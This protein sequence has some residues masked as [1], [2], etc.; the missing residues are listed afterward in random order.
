[1]SRTA[2]AALGILLAIAGAR[3]EELDLRELERVRVDPASGALLLARVD[4]EVGTGPAA[5]RLE[6][7][8]RPFGGLR[9]E[10]GAH[11]STVLDVRLVRGEPAHVKS[12]RGAWLPVGPEAG[13][14]LSEGPDGA[15]VEGLEPG[16]AFVFDARGRL[17]RIETAA[18][19]LRLVR[20]EDGLVRALEGPWG[21]VAIERD[22]LGQVRELLTPAGRR[23]RWERD[24]QG[25][26]LSVSDGRA[27]ARYAYDRRGLLCELAGGLARIE[28]D[29]AGRVTRLEGPGVDPVRVGYERVAGLGTRARLER[30]GLQGEVLAGADGRSLSAREPGGRRCEVGFDA[31]LRP[32]TI[33]CEGE[34]QRLV[35]DERGL[36]SA[37]V[38]PRGEA[39]LRRGEDGRVVRVLGPGGL[40]DLGAAAVGDAAS[41]S[42]LERDAD[43]RLL[44][45]RHA[46]GAVTRLEDDGRLRVTRDAAGRRVQS[47]RLDASGRVVSRVDACGR[48]EA[49]EWSPQGRLLAVRRGEVEQARLE[50][51]AA[52]R[53]G[54]L[55]DAQ[56]GRTVVAALDSFTTAVIDP[57]CGREQV[58]LDAQGR[59]VGQV[60]GATAINL[61]RNEL[62]QLVGRRGPRLAETFR[63]DARGR[64]VEQRGG[65]AVVSQE[66]DEQGR[67]TRVR[68]GSGL[69][70]TVRFDARGR[71]AGLELPTGALSYERDAAGRLVAIGLGGEQRIAIERDGAGRRAAVRFPNGVVTR[72]TRDAGGRLVEVRTD[73]AAE[74]V[75]RRAY[76][77]D[78]AGR[79]IG[80]EDEAGRRTRWTHDA[81][82]RLAGEETARGARAW[83]RDA[84]GNAVEETVGGVALVS[85]HAPGSRLVRRGQETFRWA[86]TGELLARKTAAGET[87][88]EWDD[89]GRLSAARLA[90]GRTARWGRTPDG[91]VAWREEAG[92]RTSWLHDGEQRVAAREADGL[93]TGWVY[94]EDGH[95]D[96]L[97]ARRDGRWFFFHL[98]RLGS[99]I[100]VTDEAG[101]VAARYEWDAEGRPLAAAGELAWNDLGWA[102]RP[103]DPLTGLVDLRAR[104]YDPELGRFLSPD[105]AR[106]RGGWSLYAYVD[107]LPHRLVDP[108]GTDAVDPETDERVRRELEGVLGRVP[109]WVETAIRQAD[110]PPERKLSVAVAYAEQGGWLDS[111]EAAILK[112][113]ALNVI[114]GRLGIPDY[115]PTGPV[116]SNFDAALLSFTIAL[117]TGAHP[118]AALVATLGG[119]LLSEGLEWWRDNHHQWAP[120][121]IY[122]VPGGWASA[123]LPGAVF[124]TPEELQAAYER[125]LDRPGVD[126]VAEAR[127]QGEWR[128]RIGPDGLLYTAILPGRGFATAR[129]LYDAV[130]AA[131][132][133]GTIDPSVCVVW[134]NLDLDALER[135]AQILLLEHALGIEILAELGIPVLA[136]GDRYSTPLIPDQRYA[137]IRALIADVEF[138]LEFELAAQNDRV[139]F[140]PLPP[141]VYGPPAPVRSFSHYTTPLMPGARY[142]TLPEAKAAI[143]AYLEDELQVRVAPRPQTTGPVITNANQQT[144][145]GESLQGPWW[146]PRVGGRTTYYTR[147]DLLR[148]HRGLAV[149]G[150]TGTLP[151]ESDGNS[152][153]VPPR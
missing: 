16:R 138:V 130:L 3:A 129:A 149:K 95:D 113:L 142:P 64:L 14:R 131:R 137:N 124:R 41:A 67:V 87:R 7:T 5:L 43:G 119:V 121:D 65:E 26:L 46:D 146:S 125:W 70:L 37:C 39:R 143:E 18:G 20:G 127:R 51:D 136:S 108:L 66:R 38:T 58:R 78:E 85:S 49:F 76:A 111:E 30:G 152:C 11:W 74:P 24:P 81:A 23:V 109:E 55:V 86:E 21:R 99:V 120:G 59:P 50:W 10:A 73:R 83:R 114:A 13:L 63:W 34:E 100:A 22:E 80:A 126:L 105:P 1:M 57:A 150:A 93:L 42:R 35:Y 48:E 54:A 32:G 12:P 2:A 98:D 151:P 139:T 56:G 122:P 110:L 118:A 107:G 144:S 145:F 82:G 77:W 33:R 15:R 128:L 52:G 44:A 79:L 133:A 148:A 25:R 123:H 84:L 101:Q 17:S 141:G 104:V 45:L 8:W 68:D 27:V 116:D 94:G 153:P 90:D 132:R 72:W 140:P 89:L 71:R 47:T 117:A 88:Y 135:L 6:R 112:D 4:L 19:A 36:L 62:G 75:A 53:L 40:I 60:R 28:W 29:E 69:E 115:V 31:L 91:R 103:R 61:I 102:A 97:A 134:P 92:R 106:Q 96:L 9:V 147:G